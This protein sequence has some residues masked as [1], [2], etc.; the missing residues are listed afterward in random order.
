MRWTETHGNPA[1][2]RH[3]VRVDLARFQA[4][5]SSSCQ[6]GIIV[7]TIVDEVASPTEQ[8]HF[9]QSLNSSIIDIGSLQFLKEEKDVLSLLS[10]L[11]HNTKPVGHQVKASL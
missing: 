10:F 9:T 5:P 1:L 7:H 4:S 8:E 2:R 3:G 6:Y 11:I